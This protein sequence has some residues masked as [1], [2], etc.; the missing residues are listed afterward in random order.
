[1]TSMDKDLFDAVYSISGQRKRRHYINNEAVMPDDRD[2]KEMIDK[3][4]EF[5][6]IYSSHE[7]V[8]MVRL[9]LEQL[10]EELGDG[11]SKEDPDA[12]KNLKRGE[13]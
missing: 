10:K 4:L 8:S 6:E 5:L 13:Y 11:T 2:V 1:M 7:R 12:P 3:L 9:S